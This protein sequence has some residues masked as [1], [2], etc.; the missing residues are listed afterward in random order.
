MSVW[1]VWAVW[2]IRSV[3]SIWAIRSIWAIH[4]SVNLAI[5]VHIANIVL[6]AVAAVIAT[7]RSTI[8]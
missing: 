4:L 2:S 8:D 5:V 1:A 7:P 3:W 6:P